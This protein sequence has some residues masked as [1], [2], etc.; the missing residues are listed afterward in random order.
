MNTSFLKTFVY[1]YSYADHYD[2]DFQTARFLRGEYDAIVGSMSHEETDADPFTGTQYV[3]SYRYSG[4]VFCGNYM[5]Q[6]AWFLLT[7]SDPEAQI[8]YEKVL[9]APLLEMFPVEM[10]AAY[11]RLEEADPKLVQTTALAIRNFCSKCRRNFA[12]QK[13]LQ[14]HVAKNTCKH[15]TTKCDC[16][17]WFVNDR[18]L[19]THLKRAQ[20]HKTDTLPV[21]NSAFRIHKRQLMV[22]DPV[23]C[24]PYNSIILYCGCGR[25]FKSEVNLKTHLEKC[26]FL[27]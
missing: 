3:R 9:R 23:L 5:W 14:D 17:K 19:K 4:N 13:G 12:T 22:A 11:Y 21:A 26:R 1:S 7:Q 6:G 20:N 25:T 18:G 10:S 24:C 8:W 27:D 2:R 15:K 16:G